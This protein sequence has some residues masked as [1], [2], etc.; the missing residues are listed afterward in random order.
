MRQSVE[1]GAG[2]RLVIPAPM[3]TALGMKVGDRLSVRWDGDE[4]RVCTSEAALR[5]IQE[6]L[7]QLD[8]DGRDGVDAF[9]AERRRAAANELEEFGDD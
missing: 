7:R 9:L 3:R 6:R 4:L 2:G 8:P 1:L 5:R